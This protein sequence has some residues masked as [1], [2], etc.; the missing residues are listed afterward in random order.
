MRAMILAAGFGTRLRPL[1]D[2]KPKA[3]IP[4]VNKPIIGRVIE[5]LKGHGV[6]R[7]VVNAHHHYRQI[8]DYLNEGKPFGLDIDVRVETEIL[9]TGGGIRNTVD[10]WDNDPFIVINS[11]IVTNIHLARAYE[12][13]RKSGALVTLI[14]HDCKPFNQIKTDNKQYVTDIAQTGGPGRLAFAGIHIM[15]PDLLSYIR[16]GKFADIIECYRQLIL[17]GKAIMAYLSK[18]H[19][20]HDIGTVGS[21]VRANRAL[22]G[23]TLSLGPGSH[24]DHSA[25]L[26]EWA[27]IGENNHLEKDVTVKRSILW[28]E[29]RVKKATRIIDS[30]VTS[31]RVI[32]RDLFGEIC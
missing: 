3:L 10:F 9:G 24:V 14:L 28:E 12:H 16:E 26:E 13:H 8:L 15:D 4:V 23:G 20:W 29:V 7:I 21:Y 19:Y 25:N 30:I 11:D 31:S 17:S 27:I 2:K 6:S 1:T 22:L 18:G 5:Y 32:D